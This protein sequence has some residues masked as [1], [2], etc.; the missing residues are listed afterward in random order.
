[1]FL[2]SLK[3]FI[4]S[5]AV[6]CFDGNEYMSRRT[7]WL[8][9]EAVALHLL[10]SYGNSK[11]P[12]VIYGDKEN[13]MLVCIFGILKAGRPYVVIPSYYPV[14]RIDAILS[15]CGA[16]V[17]FNPCSEKLDRKGYDILTSENI[18]EL[19]EKY[20]SSEVDESNYVQEKDD[21][22]LIYTSG[23][24][25]VPKGVRITA[26]N[27]ETRIRQMS[28]VIS[29]AIPKADTRTVMFSSYAF[30][31]SFYNVYYMFATEGV[32]LY[33]LSRK[34][35]HDHALLVNHLL[36]IQPHT[37]AGTPSMFRR[38]LTSDDFDCNSFPSLSLITMGGEPL[39]AELALLIKERFPTIRLLNIYGMTELASGPMVCVITDEML[40]DK[41]AVLPIGKPMADATAII[42]DDNSNEITEDN[43][44]GE[45]IIKG[46]CVSN[47][48]LNRPEL[49]NE[50]FFTDENGNKAYRTRD[51]VYRLNGFYYFAGRRDNRVK[52]GG[53]RIEL[54][55]VEAN[56][57][58]LNMVRD[59][60][61]TVKELPAPSLVAYVV[62]EDPLVSN[63]AAMLAIKAGLKER[64]ESHM[65]PQ[66]IVFVDELPKNINL[67][68]DRVALKALANKD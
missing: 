63:M 68:T 2:Q 22:C 23:S 15:D 44:V 5:D 61:V 40:K 39:T 1:M 25:G 31:A 34:T 46:K 6:A 7:F 54:E 19:V 66:K 67:K 45:L 49:T 59:C 56:M 10:N 13:D 57:K 62:K 26:E 42:V 50:V 65:I 38:L 32:S 30:S 18:T 48:Y 51:L 4:N 12:V 41:E 52:I 20:A 17:I 60:A 58:Y 35:I 55:D 36:K 27:V 47:G 24:T 3:K 29:P 37:L 16:K 9:T 33:N 8:R 11:E 14:H 43:L 28:E 53:N 64:V 21:I